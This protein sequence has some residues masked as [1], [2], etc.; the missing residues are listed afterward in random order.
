M[1]CPALDW[2]G[3]FPSYSGG[4]SLRHRL[5]LPVSQHVVGGF[6]FLFGWAFIEALL[7]R[8]TP[9]RRILFPFLFGRAF[10]EG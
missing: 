3:D 7:H 4:L 1:D 5:P 9:A 6:P 10:I 8:C 2:N